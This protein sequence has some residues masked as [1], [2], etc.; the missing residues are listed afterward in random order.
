MNA[1]VMVG[2]QEK[3]LRS[4]MNDYISKPVKKDNFVKVLENY[5]AYTES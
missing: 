1:N 4:K 2:D 5:F 3:Y